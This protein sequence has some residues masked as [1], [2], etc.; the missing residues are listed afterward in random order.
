MRVLLIEDDASLAS[1]TE[2]MLE[3]ETFEIDTTRFGQEGIYLGKLDQH[4]IILLDLNLPDISGFE[5]LRSLRDSMVKTPVIIVSG[6]AGI[7]DKV[8]AL[9]TGAD[10]FLTKP[11]QKS[12]LIARMEAVVRRSGGHSETLLIKTGDLIVDLASKTAEI[13]GVRIHLT[14][15]EYLIL[16]LLSLRKGATLTKE[17]LLNYLYDGMDEPELKII[18][19]FMCKL[20]KKLAQAS[21]GANF[22]HTNRG[23]GYVLQEPPGEATRG[24][25]R[26]THVFTDNRSTDAVVLPG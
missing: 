16:E 21:K 15:K 4:D 14:G 5:V 1:S 20:R 11:F 17:M 9:R 23:N 6:R 19:V 13:N 22:I 10:D 3:L 8:A 26:R 18:D 25:E 24:A 7:K 12:E 2:L